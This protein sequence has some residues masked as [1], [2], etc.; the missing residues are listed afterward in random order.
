MTDRHFFY[1][2]FHRCW[3]HEHS[4]LNVLMI[5]VRWLASIVERSLSK[6]L[7]KLLSINALI[8]LDNLRKFGVFFPVF[9]FFFFFLKWCKNCYQSSYTWDIHFPVGIF[10]QTPQLHIITKTGKERICYFNMIYQQYWIGA[11]GKCKNPSIAFALNWIRNTIYCLFAL[12][13]TVYDLFSQSKFKSLPLYMGLRCAR[14]ESF[15][16]QTNSI[17]LTMF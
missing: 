4:T 1:F 13:L 6:R 5:V 11:G 10:H 9:S 8:D 16:F 7:I 12:L 15:S 17:L 3:I 2:A 14:A